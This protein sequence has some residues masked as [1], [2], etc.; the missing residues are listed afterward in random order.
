MDPWRG[1]HRPME[2]KSKCINLK[3][4]IDLYFLFKFKDIIKNH[5]NMITIVFEDHQPIINHQPSTNYPT[6]NEESLEFL[7]IR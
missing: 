5:F 4:K 3:K 2:T 1:V 7:L 6:P